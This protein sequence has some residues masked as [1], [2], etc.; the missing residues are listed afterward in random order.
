MLGKK[1]EKKIE[2][3]KEKERKKKEKKLRK[4]VKKRRKRET[5]EREGRLN[6]QVSLLGA[7]C[8]R[9]DMG[10]SDLILNGFGEGLAGVLKGFGEGFR[11]LG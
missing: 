3:R 11:I 9:G 2:K 6:C 5:E 10:A 8:I 7:T 4:K 1:K